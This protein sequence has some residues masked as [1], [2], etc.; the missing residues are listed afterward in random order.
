MCPQCIAILLKLYHVCVVYTCVHKCGCTRTC[1]CVC[2]IVCECVYVCVW[3]GG[4][5]CNMCGM[6][7]VCVFTTMDGCV[8]ASV[9]V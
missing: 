6:Y 3:G 1:I 9:G 2:A 4:G 8:C 7:T 5:M